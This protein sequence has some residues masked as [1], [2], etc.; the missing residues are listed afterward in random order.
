MLPNTDTKSL[1]AGEMEIIKLDAD[2]ASKRENYIK[3]YVLVGKE[4]R[5]LVETGPRNAHEILI[6]SLKSNG[7]KLQEIDAILL[8]HIHLDHAGG[9]GALVRECSCKVYVHPKGLKHLADPRKLNEAARVALGKDVF[10]AY[11]PA[12]P[13]PENALVATSDGETLEF[14]DVKVNVVHT[15]GHAPHHQAFLSEGVLFPGDAL[16][17]LTTWVGAYTPTTPHK[18]LLNI[19]ID[20]V[21]KL[22]RLEPK[23]IAFTHRGFLRGKENAL[24]QMTGY[25]EQLRTWYQTIW[26]RARTC[27]EDVWCLYNYLKRSDPH[28]GTLEERGELDKSTLLK[29]SVRMSIYGI[30]KYIYPS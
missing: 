20:S 29:N 5:V 27:G 14:G 15:P 25:L 13:V 4:G 7:F 8:T 30:Y 1:K 6:D 28:L 21:D 12:E 3:A 11:G 16:G 23:A 9:V 24:D 17:E 19:L 22:I 18:V 10:E 26:I 2:P